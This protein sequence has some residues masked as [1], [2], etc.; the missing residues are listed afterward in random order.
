MAIPASQIVQVNPS[1]ISG[2]G[3]ALALNG[4]FLTN[5]TA[6]PIGAVQQ[7]TTAAS[8]AAFF[9]ALSNEAAQAAVYFQGRNNATIMPAQLGFTQ[10]PSAAVSAWL[11]G[12]SVATLTLEQLKAFSGTISLTVNG[13]LITSSTINLSAATSFSNAAT[14]IQAGFTSPPFAVSFDSQ[15]GAFLF[16]TTLTGVTATI[17]AATGTLATSLMLTAA[18]GATTS[19]GSAQGVPATTMNAITTNTLNWGAFSTVFEP[20][21]SD[22]IG[23]ALWTNQQNNRF[24]YVMW[25]SEAA[26][27]TVPDTTSSLAQIQALNYSGICGIYCSPVTDPTGLAAGMVLGVTASIDFNRPNARGTYAFKY[28]NG[29]PVT[30][31]DPNTANNLKT[32]G[33]NYIGT[34]ATANQN[35]TFLYSGQVTGAYLFIDEYVNQVYLN[36]QLQ[37]ALMSLLTSVPSIPYNTAGYALI[38][39]ACLTAITQAVTFGS[40]RQG[41][42]LSA[43]QAAN[44]NNAAGLQIDQVLSSQG[45]YLQILPAT[46]QVR[47]ARQ[48]PP[49]TLWYMDGGAVQQITLASVLVQ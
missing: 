9:G 15:R 37:L 25:S 39:A 28:T 41:I 32:N 4:I 14:I 42:P 2:G 36:S 23:F 34:W 26:A 33:Y 6:V 10:Y 16:T 35:F 1:V 48:S 44:V 24:L 3:N 12:A 31:I 13:T 5:N 7:F 38:N 29:V 49:M 47:A 45:W 43:L 27:L 20:S 30:V 22:K 11:R 40:I 19:Q 18:T 21:V 17:T 46:S 8:V